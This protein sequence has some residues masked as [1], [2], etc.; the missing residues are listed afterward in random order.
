MMT[1]YLRLANRDDLQTPVHHYIHPVSGR[2]V[3]LVTTMPFGEPAYY[4][5]LTTVIGD[6]ESDGAVVHREGSDHVPVAEDTSTAEEQKLLAD[7]RRAHRME[8][9]RVALTGLVGHHSGLGH[10]P[11][12]RYIDLSTLDIIRI[13]GRRSITD[14]IQPTLA[15][16]NWP[17][18][19]PRPVY[20]FRLLIAVGLRLGAITAR[21]GTPPRHR[22]GFETVVARRTAVALDGVAGTRQ[23]VVLVWN[24]AYT[25]S[26]DN[27]LRNAGYQRIDTDWYTA[28]T[29][30]TVFRACR[31]LIHN[32][33]PKLPGS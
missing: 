1:P 26:L 2:R 13:A 27:G 5:R 22:R 15:A 31:D 7:W 6:C 4:S 29:L 9:N 32:L 16:S 33:R 14:R 23:D 11:S 17:L 24:A 20:A 28:I 8:A 30:P 19:D 25:P 21:F 10:R 18:D 3:T 12:W